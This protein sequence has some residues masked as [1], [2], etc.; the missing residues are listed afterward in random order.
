V[1]LLVG[2]FQG[3]SSGH[4]TPS[5]WTTFLG[6]C[7]TSLQ[8]STRA[9]PIA[10]TVMAAVI[11]AGL[12]CG[13]GISLWRTDGSGEWT[14][15]SCRSATLCCHRTFEKHLRQRT[16]NVES[17]KGSPCS[18]EIDRMHHDSY[19][20]KIPSSSLSKRAIF[21]TKQISSP[22]RKIYLASALSMLN[23]TII[24]QTSLIND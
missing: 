2:E 12:D 9:E 5:D 23:I 6:P 17:R 1:L 3:V 19:L 16:I 10:I 15:L 21:K 22:V 13:Y 4:N 14:T 20:N 24:H 11:P 8:P 18:Y 7:V